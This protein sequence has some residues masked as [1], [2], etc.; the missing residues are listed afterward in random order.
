MT[1]ICAACVTEV[2]RDQAFGAAGPYGASWFHRDFDQCAK[3][4][5]RTKTQE[6]QYRALQNE[7]DPQ[8]PEELST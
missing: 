2:E 7:R 6:A 3:N 1:V 4:R 5:A 8:E